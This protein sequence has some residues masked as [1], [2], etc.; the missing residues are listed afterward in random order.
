M[1][2]WQII[3]TAILTLALIIAAEKMLVSEKE[4][5]KKAL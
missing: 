4:N 5:E 3:V 2:V 1:H